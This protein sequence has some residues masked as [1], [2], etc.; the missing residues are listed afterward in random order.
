MHV[1][2]TLDFNVQPL[3]E[4]HYDDVSRIYLEG[5]ATGNATFQTESPDWATWDKVHLPHSRLVAVKKQEVVGWA[6]LTPV[7]GRCVYRGVAE[8]SVY[9]GANHQGQG[10]GKLL[11][12]NLIQEAEANGIWTLQAGIF[13]E[14]K[15]SLT[16][17]QKCGFRVVGVREKIGQLHGT[18][19]DVCFLER[20]SKVVGL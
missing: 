12:N 4:R 9:I 15:A 1:L 3:A 2:T 16:L 11:L 14:N 13:K 17:H 20:R 8:V 18:W 7:S 19:R 5:I 6:A 10:L